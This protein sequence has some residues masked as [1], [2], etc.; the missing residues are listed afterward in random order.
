MR[1]S[2]VSCHGRRKEALRVWVSV[3]TTIHFNSIEIPL[4]LQ[5]DSKAISI[6]ILLF[7]SYMPS[8]NSIEI[9]PACFADALTCMLEESLH[10]PWGI[11]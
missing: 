2:L 11:K 10:F 8:Y 1:I 9:A 3:L 6:V 5:A 4:C 7:D